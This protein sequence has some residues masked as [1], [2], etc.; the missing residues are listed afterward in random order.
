MQ[1][2]GFLMG[3]KLIDAGKVKKTYK[4]LFND[5]QEVGKNIFINR[6]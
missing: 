6:K 4:E 1:M 2:A 3:V 5:I